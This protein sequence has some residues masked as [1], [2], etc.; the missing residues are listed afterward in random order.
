QETMDY[1]HFMALNKQNIPLVFYDRVCLNDIFPT[2]VSDNI[3]SAQKATEHL[4]DTG[5]RRVAFIGGSNHLEI[6]KQRKSGYLNALRERRIPIE[7]ELVF[8]KYLGYD[9]GYEGTV[10]FLNLPNPP[11]AII[12]M[13]DSIAFGAMQAIKERGLKIPQDIALVG[14]TDEL[15][16][17]YVEPSLTAVTHQTYKM[18]KQACKLLFKAIDG[19]KKAYRV[20][21][22]SS[23][24]IRRS[25]MKKEKER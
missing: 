21:V 13:N 5:S 3:L 11:D 1:N 12:A 8:C 6:V 19:D 4:L 15:H 23:L 17:N 10:R 9:V 2:V 25:S 18:G 24:D 14:Y 16:S 20:V 7:P 22:P